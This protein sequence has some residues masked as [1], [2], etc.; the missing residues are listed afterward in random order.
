MAFG[1][2]AAKEDASV[3]DDDLDAPLTAD[4]I[5]TLAANRDPNARLEAETPDE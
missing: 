1:I 4:E 2:T 5:M 3:Q